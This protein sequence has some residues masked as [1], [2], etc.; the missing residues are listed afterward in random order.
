MDENVCCPF[1]RVVDCRDTDE[2][3]H[4]YCDSQYIIKEI[5]VSNDYVKEFCLGVFTECKYYPRG[6]E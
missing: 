1:L 4:L 6:E 5:V 2:H 3:A